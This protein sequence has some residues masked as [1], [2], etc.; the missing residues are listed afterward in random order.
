M[1]LKNVD[2]M[3]KIQLQKE[4]RGSTRQKWIDRDEMVCDL[5]CVFYWD[6]QGDMAYLVISVV[7]ISMMMWSDFIQLCRKVPHILNRD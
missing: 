2:Q 4:G 5:E 3:F 6:R 7:V 1:A